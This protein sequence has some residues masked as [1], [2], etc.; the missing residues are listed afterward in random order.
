MCVSTGTA[1]AAADPS[2]ELDVN[3]PETIDITD[4]RDAPSEV[5]VE[6]EE[7]AEDSE[8][9]LK[10]ED[11][12][13]EKGAAMGFPEAQRK[14]NAHRLRLANAATEAESEVTNCAP[15]AVSTT[16]PARR[17]RAN[18]AWRQAQRID[19][20]HVSMIA[21]SDGL[22]ESS[23]ERTPAAAE[24][25]DEDARPAVIANAPTALAD[26]GRVPRGGRLVQRSWPYTGCRVALRG[27]DTS[28]LEEP[29]L[30]PDGTYL[31]WIE[32][33]MFLLLEDV[34]HYQAT[35][36]AEF[37]LCAEISSIMRMEKSSLRI[38]DFLTEDATD[39]LHRRLNKMIGKA[40]RGK[41]KVFSFND[42]LEDKE[43]SLYKKYTQKSY[44]NNINWSLGEEELA[45][46][47]EV[48]YTV[49]AESTAFFSLD[50]GEAHRWQNEFENGHSEDENE[51]D[52]DLCVRMGPRPRKRRNI[53][54]GDPSIKMK[55]VM[56]YEVFVRSVR[57][58]V[59]DDPPALDYEA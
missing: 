38:V 29:S 36:R 3:E 14:L 22:D 1:A 35:H 21:E 31:C 11:S 10:G 16:G 59:Q 50:D 54:S 9:N 39:W 51:Y 48:T 33:E 41:R 44:V 27:L 17:P 55:V 46:K 20:R 37:H 56:R 25:L 4:G 8:D 13:S 40:H 26:T 34:T 58:I 12:E 32:T 6:A 2:S 24:T 43:I 7:E 23:A 53:D 49:S 57:F 18:V 42:R 47:V 19:Q 45:K 5:E 52:D 28:E 15:P 30:N